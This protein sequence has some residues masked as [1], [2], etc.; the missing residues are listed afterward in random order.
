MTLESFKTLLFKTKSR[1]WIADRIEYGDVDQFAEFYFDIIEKN[2]YTPN[3]IFIRSGVDGIIKSFNN[4]KPKDRPKQLFEEFE[5]LIKDRE[6]EWCGDDSP[7]ERYSFERGHRY[8]KYTID[9]LIKILRQSQRFDLTE[10]YHTWDGIFSSNNHYDLVEGFN[11]WVD[12][13][14]ET[15]LDWLSRLELVPDKKLRFQMW[16]DLSRE[17]IRHSI[18]ESARYYFPFAIDNCINGYDPNISKHRFQKCVANGRRK[19]VEKGGKKNWF[20]KQETG[21]LSRKLLKGTGFTPGN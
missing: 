11:E 12:L 16:E 14:L 15:V 17:S 20:I 19:I 13:K 6:Y 4:K 1:S 18:F 7:Q 9:D 3:K 2:R 5:Q 21:I 10:E 8:F